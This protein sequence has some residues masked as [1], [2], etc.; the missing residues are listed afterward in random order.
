MSE[1]KLAIEIAQIDCVEI[2]DVDFSEAGEDKVLE[3]LAA[4]S[5]CS[6]HQYTSL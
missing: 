1:E 6:N 3:K 4:Y 5:T 2:Y